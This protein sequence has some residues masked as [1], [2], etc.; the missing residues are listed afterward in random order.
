MGV[1]P[2]KETLK[3]ILTIRL[4]DQCQDWS[5]DDDKGK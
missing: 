5:Y 1:G 2:G 3:G 4:P